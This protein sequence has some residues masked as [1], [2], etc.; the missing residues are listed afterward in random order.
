MSSLKSIVLCK[1]PKCSKGNIFTESNPYHLSKLTE[2]VDA[3]P[4]C[5]FSLKNETGFHFLSMYMSYIISCA[6]C[7]IVIIPGTY[8][9]GLDNFPYVLIFNAIFLILL[10]PLIFRWSRMLSYWVTSKFNFK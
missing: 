2:M 7:G 3:C 10:M 8:I 4:V 9:V 6:I 5:G 1:C